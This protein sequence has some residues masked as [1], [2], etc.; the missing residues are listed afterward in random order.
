M[1]HKIDLYRRLTRISAYQELADLRAEFVDRFGPPP[2]PVE[3]LLEIIEL[4]MDAA[5]WFVSSIYREDKFLVFQYRDR[6]RIE[7]LAR[8]QKGQLRIVDDKSAYLPVPA[9]LLSSSD[10]DALFHLAKSVLRP[11][12]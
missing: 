7:Q 4:K 9:P 2:R 1:R 5:L 8:Q 12:K 6:G 3:R 10:P 11:S